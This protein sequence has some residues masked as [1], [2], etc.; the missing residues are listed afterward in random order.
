[1]STDKAMKAIQRIGRLRRPPVD[2]FV[3]PVEKSL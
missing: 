1:M 3:E 2:F